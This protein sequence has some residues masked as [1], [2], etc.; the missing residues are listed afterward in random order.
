MTTMREAWRPPRTENAIAIIGWSTRFPAFAAKT[1]NRGRLSD[2]FGFDA[3]LFKLTPAEVRST[4]PQHRVFLECCWEAFAHAGYVPTNGFTGV[5]AACAPSTYALE[6]LST[7]RWSEELRRGTDKDYLPAFVSQIL[8]FVGPSLAV[9]SACASAIAAIHVACQS[10]IAGECD[11]A[12]A[13]AVSI[14]GAIDARGREFAPFARIADGAGAF[15]LKPLLK[16]EEDGDYVHAVILGSALAH[17]GSRTSPGIADTN[18]VRYVQRASLAVAGIDPS[19]VGYI[20]LHCSGP[21]AADSIE[22]MALRAAYGSG[23]ELPEFGSCRKNILYAGV[24]S[25]VAGVRHAIERVQS[26]GLEE[27]SDQATIRV[28]SE[29]SRTEPRIAAVN[30]IGMTGTH[31]HLII[32]EG[33]RHGFQCT[34]AVDDLQTVLLS[35]RTHSGLREYAKALMEHCRGRE[36][37]LPLADISWTL[38]NGREHFPIRAV[39]FARNGDQLL[40]DLEAIAAGDFGRTPHSESLPEKFATAALQWLAGSAAAWPLA[41]TRGRSI[42]LPWAPLERQV[43]RCVI[44]AEIA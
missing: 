15:L 43:F 33:P 9:Q 31:G 7:G 23:R 14:L 20:E 29:R 19:D 30:A 12:I 6:A 41:V 18:I 2:A 28:T 26:S 16:A 40:T 38:M 42:P 17:A 13:G 1:K 4:D 35:A 10:L 3:A 25:G 8:G 11:T 39:S 22:T 36:P 5:Y 21:E 37:G 24:A 32:S 34:P 27:P 44:G